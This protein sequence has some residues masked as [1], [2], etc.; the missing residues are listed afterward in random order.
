MRSRPHTTLYGVGD[1]TLQAR[2]KSELKM[3]EWTHKRYHHANQLH[4]IFQTHGA[5][6]L[7]VRY[8]LAQGEIAQ[9][10]QFNIRIVGFITLD[11]DNRQLSLDNPLSAD[12]VETKGER[13]R[14]F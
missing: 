6:D 14:V 3:E 4:D 5:R 8:P 12:Y 10:K 13:L 11:T 7:V 1:G 2:G 9:P